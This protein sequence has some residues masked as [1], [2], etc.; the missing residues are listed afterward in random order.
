MYNK[1]MITP[2]T[3]LILLQCPIELDQR[4]QL[5]F[6]N[7]TAQYN[8]FHGLNKL[9]QDGFTY[10]RK[11]GK[12]RYP[13]C[14]DDLWQYNYCMYRNTS[15][16]NKWFYAFITDIEYLND[17]TSLISIKTDV[18][19]SWQFDLTFK[20]TFVVREHVNDDTFG[21]HTIDE[22]LNYG[23]YIC[24][25]VQNIVYAD[26]ENANSLMVAFQVTTPDVSPAGQTGVNVFPTQVRGI[27]N[28]IPQGCFI[29]GFPYSDDAAGQ[30]SAVV[31]AYDAV[32]KADAIVSI[33]LIPKACSGWV[34]KRGTGVYDV[35]DEWYVPIFSRGATSLLG[36]SV[37]RNT[38][39]QG[40]VPKN[41]KV[42][43]YPY[44]Y[45]YATNNAGQDI[46]YCYENFNGDP[47]FEVRGALEQG[48]AIKMIPQNSKVT[49]GYPSVTGDG[50]VESLSGGKLPVVSWASNFYLN[51]IA[52]N[53]SNLEL[54]AGLTAARFGTSILSSMVSGGFGSDAHMSKSGNVV[55]G[56]SVS[57]ATSSAAGMVNS[58]LS[59]ADSVKDIMQQDREARMIP[60]SARGNTNCG[61]I[62]FSANQNKFTFRKMSIKAEYAKIIDDYFSAYGY[63][64]NSFKLPNRTGRQNWNYVQTTGCNIEGAVPQIDLQEI[65]S[66]FDSGITLWHNAST[67]LDYSQSNNI[68]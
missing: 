61:S 41:N 5:T 63:K 16:G 45:L 11:D 60:P 30:I 6:S 22:G 3:D 15:H 67:F 53:G 54:E 24:N 59:M 8:Y 35:A 25:G 23:D 21:I 46:T 19:Q 33:F 50:W 31:G 68:V 36:A 1:I 55:G 17:N 20:N 52:V 66:M 4:N 37:S 47:A 43:C 62:Q 12:I 44:N 26:T 29:F 13:A 65:K 38:S 58:T 34:S 2:N 39:L 40:Y 49:S 18:W 51:W 56:A 7:A 14:A 57:G 10:Q 42:F 32:G 9:E 64:V 28:G 27:Y 48:G